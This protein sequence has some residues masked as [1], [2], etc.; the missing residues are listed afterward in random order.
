MLLVYSMK[1]KLNQRLYKKQQ[2]INT[3]KW[4][5]RKIKMIRASFF[6]LIFIVT[7]TLLSPSTIGSSSDDDVIHQTLRVSDVAMSYVEEQIIKD[8]E[9][10]EYTNRIKD[11]AFEEIDCLAQNIYHE[12]RND[13]LAGQ[14]AVADVVL[15]RV[16]DKRFPNTICDVVKEGPLYESAKTRL[17]K[18][19][20]DAIYFPVKNKCQF[21]WYCDGEDDITNED[22]AW[23]QAQTIAYMILGN[24]TF[25]GIT[26][27]STHYHATYVNPRW[28]KTKYPIGRIGKHKF[29]RWL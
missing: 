7:S 3:E 13:M 10:N 1:K 9:H 18:D 17:T 21:S 16:D 11:Y 27:G 24:L 6:I 14:F 29:Y 4:K 26:E 2:R 28:A 8:E 23:R 22:L 5:L 15:N 25:R 12:A 19:P 20:N